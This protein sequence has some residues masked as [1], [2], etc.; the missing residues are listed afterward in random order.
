MGR[1]RFE[2]VEVAGAPADH[3]RGGEGPS[4]LFLHGWGVGPRSYAGSLSRLAGIGLEVAAP[5]LPGFGGT[6]ALEGASCDFSGYARWL[7]SYLDTLGTTEPV[8]VVGH[9]FGGGVAIQLAHDIPERVRAVVVCNAVGGATR[10]GPA[11][12]PWWEWGRYLGSD[13]LALESVVRVLPAVLGEAVPN[14]VQNPLA[15]WRVGEFVRRADLRREVHVLTD[16]C[17]P[18]TVVWSDRDRLVP[19]GSFATLCSAAGV[20]GVVVPGHHSWL[21]A[22]PGRF[23]DV[24]LRALAEAGV[25]EEALGLTA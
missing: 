23:A 21:I 6:P 10:L 13:L 20:D 19:H 24:V 4:L 22:D 8:V 14:F 3:G 7:S 11:D 9:S 25:V 5:A 12:R 1:I 2:R 18:F 15:M 17:T 16:R